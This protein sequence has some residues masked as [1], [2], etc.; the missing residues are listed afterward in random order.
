MVKK[1]KLLHRIFIILFAIIAISCQE[2]KKFGTPNV[3][4][5]ELQSDLNKW[6]RYHYT[7]I[8]L[9][10]NFNALNEHSKDISKLDFIQNL[11]TGNFIP[12]KMNSTKS[13]TYYKLFPIKDGSNKEISKSIRNIANR[14]YKNYRLLDKQYPEYSYTDLD[15]NNYTKTSLLGNYLVIKFW[16]INCIPCV[17]EMPEINFLKNKYKN[18]DV[19]FLSLAFDEPNEL[20]EFLKDKDYDLP[21][22]SVSKS[23]VF[24]TIGINMFPTH[25]IIDKKGKVFSVTNDTK[26]LRWR[27]KD[28]LE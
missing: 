6:Y 2:R 23:Y 28:V 4:V 17:K 24:D 11:Q 18:E 26:H 20:K 7:Y 1:Q 15:G 13:T 21:T 14:N 10:S 9:T 19:I 5:I 8:D 3:D 12:I 22:I 16:F 25:I 27:L